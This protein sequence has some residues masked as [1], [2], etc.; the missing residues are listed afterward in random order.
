M[1]NVQV[2]SLALFF[3]C[4]W[5]IAKPR[6]GRRSRRENGEWNFSALMLSVGWG[7]SCVAILFRCVVHVTSSHYL[8]RASLQKLF[9]TTKQVSAPSWAVLSKGHTHNTRVCMYVYGYVCACVCVI[10]CVIPQ[11]F[12]INLFTSTLSLL[13]CFHPSCHY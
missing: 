11:A 7:A 9:T 8:C 1:S 2:L 10:S 4:P 6:A 3:L 5:M 13:I 12:I